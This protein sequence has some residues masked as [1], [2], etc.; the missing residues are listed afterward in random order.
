MLE[1][2][3]KLVHANGISGN[4]SC[5][6]NVIIE[7]LCNNVDSIKTDNM[8]NL[9]AF[10]KGTGESSARAKIMIAA[11]MDEIGVMVTH[12]D[13]NGFIRF[14]NVGWVSPY[15]AIGQRV[16]FDN[17]I[18]GTVFYE[19]KV[20]NMD[21]LK[22]DKMFI[23]IGAASYEDA[24]NLI[25]IGDTA[26]F[27]SDFIIQDNTI[28]SKV[29]DNRSGCL[30]S[31]LAAQFTNEYPNDI[32]FVFTSQEEVGIRGAGP[33]AFGI[34]PDLAI[35]LDVTD[36]GDVP[37]CKPMEVTMGKGPAIKV[38]DRSYIASPHARRLFEKVAIESKIP[39]QL[40]IMEDGGTD[41]GSI[42]ISGCGVITGGISIPV[43]YIH[44]PSEM[45]SVYDIKHGI[46]LLTNIL[47]TP[48]NEYLNN[49]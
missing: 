24:A 43:R 28:I 36:T 31:I 39:Y 8:G 42:H 4:E 2:L 47:N 48:L 34:Q 1:M 29:L 18:V 41:G 35:V 5:I 46:E 11:H 40:E 38:K 22:L 10:K 17:G 16:K 37:G 30:L 32:Y 14:A 27:V 9:I 3:K 44:S 19:Q 21:K 6:R 45:C 23:D 26:V 25:K 49:V 7:L 13:K 20:E 33:A 12:I 15:Y